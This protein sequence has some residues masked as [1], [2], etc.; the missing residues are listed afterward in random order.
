MMIQR[1]SAFT[2]I[3]TVI[4]VAVSLSMMLAL[5]LLL[6]TFNKSS[7]HGKLSAQSYDSASAV[8]REV[9]A[10]VLPA[11]AVLETH[12]FASA[13]HTSTTTSLVLQVPSI[14]SSGNV[15]TN[16]YD[17][18][19]FYTAGTNVYR[20]LEKNAL[21]ARVAGTQLLSQT[22]GALSFSYD[23]ATFS[24]IRVVTIDIETGA[25][26]KEE[27]FTTRLREQIRLRNH[28]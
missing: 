22:L 2:L 28:Q 25:T 20:L 19:A 21:S 3:E 27:V 4:V 10:F 9:E 16:T 26:V 5:S 8:L 17:Y 13:T 18:V 14:D 12:S 6:Y 15:I 23:S 24:E 11:S 1:P 7:T